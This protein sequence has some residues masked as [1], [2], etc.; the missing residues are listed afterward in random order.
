MI[1][2]DQPAAVQL[3]R[4]DT[5]TFEAHLDGRT[6]ADLT[7]APDPRGLRLA[8]DLAPALVPA[9]SDLAAVL[10]AAVA[11]AR[12]SG[13]GALALAADGNL[14]F[15]YHARAAGFTGPLRDDLV[16]ALGAAS[17]ALP[18]AAT[19]TTPTD[20]DRLVADLRMLLPGVEV[21]SARAVGP[22]RRLFRGASTGVAGTVHL[23]VRV[24]DE[25]E[26]LRVAVPVA[27]DVMAEGVALVIDTALAVRH[28]FRPLV[29]QVRIF[30]DHAIQGLRAGTVAGVA[31]ASV[32]DIHL[33]PAYALLSEME[34]LEQS[35]LDR[36]SAPGARRSSITMLPPFTRVDSVVA[37][38]FW[39]QIEFGFETSRYRDSVAFRREIGRYFGVETLE[40]AIKGGPAG[41]PPAWQ[42]ARARLAEEVSTYATTAPKEATAELFAQW[43]CTRAGPPPPAQF[44][45]ALLAQF[46]PPAGRARRGSA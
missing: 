14:R 26:P 17:A 46:F 36:S 28:R 15:R 31:E 44:F 3:R 18:S 4:K 6:M 29:G 40:H 25:P 24:P 32:R 9:S 45:G 33:N 43:W 5:H 35:I 2:R 16:L 7:L 1:G 19:P 11:E 8:I 34:L 39:H 20:Q 22:L 37:H 21:A 13:V 41:A 27:P 30:F 42:A 23:T 38:E 12:T 10:A